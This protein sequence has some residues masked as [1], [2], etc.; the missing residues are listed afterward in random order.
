MDSLNSI[1]SNKNFDEPPEVSSIKKYVQDKFKT[2]VAVQVRNSDI[3][4]N[5][6]NSALANT[7]RLRTPEIIQ[8][9]QIEK[10]LIFRI[11]G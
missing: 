5:V 8:R 2:N 11:S 3:I 7:L 9:C 6:P 4:I 1:L 10:K